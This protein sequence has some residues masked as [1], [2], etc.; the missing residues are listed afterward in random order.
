[1]A[2]PPAPAA[3]D[4]IAV[5]TEAAR[6]LSQYIQFDT[7]NPPGNEVAAVEFLADILRERGFEPCILEAAPGRANLI[8]RLSAHSKAKFPP[9]LLYTHIDVV[10]ADSA[11]WTIPP[12]EGRIK[13]GFIWGRGALDN[14]GF[15][16]I[17]LQ[18]LSL[19]KQ[20]GRPLN[21]DLIFL[22][23]ADEEVSGRYGVGWLFDH[24]PDLIKAEYV[25][26]EG[27]VGLKQ[28]GRDD[29]YLYE[30]AVAEKSTLAVKLIAHGTPG[31]ASIPH[32]D[33]PQD[34][35]VRVLTRLRRWQQPARLTDPVIEMLQTL[36]PRQRFPQSFLFANADRAWVWP[37]LQTVLEKEPLF[38]P[39]IR[40]TITLTM[41]QGG[42]SGNVIPAQAE[43][44]LDIRLLP[45]ERANTVL[46]A[47]RSVIADS[48]VA[49]E[50]EELPVM[51]NPTPAGTEFFKA[52][53]QTLRQAGPPGLAIPYLSPGTTDSRFFRRAGMKAYGFLPMLLDVRELSRIHGVDERVS[54]AN[55]RWGTQVVVETLEKLCS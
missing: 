53:A 28:A 39:L 27:G 14:K 37:L 24:H 32:P 11:G 2:N 30:I 51:H 50:V 13:D 33:N 52:L 31:H 36:A 55:L 22:A 45:G 1:V 41:L 8:V 19:L 17:F 6:L 42:L 12:F 4:W 40:N 38:S 54:T 35:L 49:I 5:E 48:K 34:R 23:A 18:A 21:R 47:L 20:S 10:P 26:D 44:N 43:A 7:T 3:I 25:W 46:A 15:G 9:C 16:I 29:D